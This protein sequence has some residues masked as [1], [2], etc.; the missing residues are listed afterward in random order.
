MD[1][2]FTLDGEPV[3]CPDGLTVAAALFHLGRRATRTTQRRGALRSLF[4]GMGVCFDCVMEI[5]GRGGVRACT[6]LV[7]PGMRVATQ[8]GATAIG[9]AA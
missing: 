1:V 5:D 8:R 4:C 7:R 6:T 3:R 2:E 9:P